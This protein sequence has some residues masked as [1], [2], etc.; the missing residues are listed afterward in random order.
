M[1][2]EGF[3]QLPWKLLNSKQYINLSFAA[4]KLLP[5]FIGKVH[6]GPRDPARYKA[7]F[8][9]CYKEGLKF[10]FSRETFRRCLRELEA[11]GFIFRIRRG[12][13]CGEDHVA[14]RYHLSNL[15]ET[16]TDG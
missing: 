10:G 12:G 9:F 14:S 1:S 3:V 16:H 7:G 4:A 13:L 6:M 5:Y 8:G 2:K 11:S 15:W